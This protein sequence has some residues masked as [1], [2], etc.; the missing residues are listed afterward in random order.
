MRERR[1]SYCTA[2]RRQPTSL[3]PSLLS[4]CSSACVR[5]LKIIRWRILGSFVVPR[6]DDEEGKRKANWWGGGGKIAEDTTTTRRRYKPKK[7]KKE[8]RKS[9][10]EEWSVGS[11]SCS[12]SHRCPCQCYCVLSSLRRFCTVVVYNNNNN[13]NNHY[14]TRPVTSSSCTNS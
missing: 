7:E 8:A 9:R 12:Y 6:P 14:N 5:S 4:F 11:I 2:L 1:A 10:A 3:P 13:N